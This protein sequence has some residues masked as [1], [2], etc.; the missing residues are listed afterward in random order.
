MKKP[1]FKFSKTHFAF[2]Y[3][4]I[5]VVFV[6][7]PLLI[8]MYYA[9]TDKYT[10]Q[11]TLSNFSLFT[12]AST[13]KIMGISFLMAFLTTLICLLLAYPLALALC[14]IK[15]NKTFIIVMIF[16]LPM[17]INSLLRI[18]SVKLL[19]NEFLQID[20]GF[21]LSLIGM[22][23]DFFPFMLLPIYTVLSNM[24]KGY[25]EA[26]NDLGANDFR[27]FMKVKL[28]LSLPGITSGVLMVFMPAVSTFAINDILGSSQYWLFGNEIYFWFQKSMYNIGSALAFVM[29]ILIILSV[30]VSSALNKITEGSG[31]TTLKNG[32]RT[33][34]KN[35]QKAKSFQ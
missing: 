2:P 35:T 22:V 19:F 26:S 6:I 9:F 13:W 32:G 15:S 8:L 25:F 24:N 7:V 30:V 31:K 16:V 17:W 14:K 12:E 33:L 28:P 21:L 4:I 34:W 10:G 29:L 23:Y 1:R 5:S 18:Y 20:K 11:F 3:T 27:T